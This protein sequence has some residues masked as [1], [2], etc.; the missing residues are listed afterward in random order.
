MEKFTLLAKI[1]QG[2]RQSVTN[3]TC[4]PPLPPLLQLQRN[5]TILSWLGK[6][7]NIKHNF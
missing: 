6:Q 1:L 2:R 4:A 5:N 3:L 7:T